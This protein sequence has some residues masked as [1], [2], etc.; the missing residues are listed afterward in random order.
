MFCHGFFGY[1]PLQPWT[2][3]ALLDAVFK[4]LGQ[5]E[6]TSPLSILSFTVLVKRWNN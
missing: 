5:E 6:Q 3:V 1:Q 2:V 4:G